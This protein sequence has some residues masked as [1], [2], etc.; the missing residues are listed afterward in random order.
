VQLTWPMKGLRT[1]IV[2][3]PY[4]A[5]MDPQP[6]EWRGRPVLDPQACR[7]ADGCAACVAVCLP[8]ALR[9]EPSG[10]GAEDAREGCLVLD[11]GRCIVCGLCVPA[12]PAGALTIQPEYELAVSAAENLRVT[13]WWEEGNGGP[14]DRR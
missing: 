14:D 7:A 4:P 3:T 11:Y 5:T 8:Q 10:Q 1:G 2:T 6:R 12:C 9:L 13:L